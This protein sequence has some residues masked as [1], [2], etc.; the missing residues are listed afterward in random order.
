MAFATEFDGIPKR[1]FVVVFAI[2]MH[3]CDYITNAALGASTG[4]RV[5]AEEIGLASICNAVGIMYRAPLRVIE[6]ISYESIPAALA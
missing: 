2:M 4:T 3:V 1:I 5:I 6:R